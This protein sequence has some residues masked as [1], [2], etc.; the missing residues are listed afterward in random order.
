[1]VGFSESAVT[2]YNSALLHFQEEDF[3]FNQHC[4]K[5]V[6]L[7]SFFSEYLSL[8]L[9]MIIPSGSPHSLT[10]HPLNGQWAHCRLQVHKDI[11]LPYH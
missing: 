1:M 4:P 11:P 6:T 3:D 8:P 10:C 2:L 5:R 9:S 7:N